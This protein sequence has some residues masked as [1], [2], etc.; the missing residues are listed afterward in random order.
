MQLVVSLK[1]KK[2]VSANAYTFIIRKAKYSK[3]KANN[4][5]HKYF[6]FHWS[7]F[8]KI[9]III[10]LL[11]GTLRVI[12]P[13][14]LKITTLW[15]EKTY[16]V[17]RIWNQFLRKLRNI[18]LWKMPVFHL[19]W[20]SIIVYSFAETACH[21]WPSNLVTLL[22]WI[23][24]AKADWWCVIPAR[25]LRWETTSLYVSLRTLLASRLI[26]HFTFCIRPLLDLT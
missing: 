15:L 10:I 14:H 19:S 12:S 18:Y 7:L 24:P 3:I 9:S 20:K 21:Q 13:F 17:W 2:V 11:S 5:E 22:M 16:W 4:N 26:S 23:A 25:W 6:S 8:G 1:S